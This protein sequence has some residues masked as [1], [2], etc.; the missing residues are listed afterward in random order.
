LAPGEW[1]IWLT[2]SDPED[3]PATVED[4]LGDESVR[5]VGFRARV[6]SER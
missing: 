4:A 1:Q 5:R 3:A 2:I 6:V